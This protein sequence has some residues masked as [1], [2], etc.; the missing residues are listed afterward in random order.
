[1]CG[2]AG[3]VDL[4]SSEIPDVGKQL[5]TLRH[6]GPDSRGVF[7][8]PGV[9]LGQTRLSIIDLVTGDPP[10]TD[11]TGAIGVAFNGEIYGFQRLR[12]RLSAN[13]HVL[14][15]QGDTE[16][17]PHLAEHLAPV[18]LCR[19][20]DG[21]FAFALWDARAKRLVLARDR[22][23]KK[24]LFYWR[25]GSRLVFGSE[26]KAVLAAE[27]VPRDL[28]E[29]A[30]PG[31]L[32][33]GYVPRPHTLFDGVHALGPA[34]VLTFDH[35]GV[36]IERYWSPPLV[37]VDA[38]QVQLRGADLDAELD[39]LLRAAVA[40]RTVA[41]VPVGAFLSG[42]IDSSIVV[43]LLAEASSTPVRT[44]TIGFDDPHGFDERPYAALVAQRYSTEHTEFVV[45][46]DAAELLETLVWHHDQP[47][48]DSSGLPTYL[49]SGLTR[50][51]VTVALSGDG[52]D[53]LFAGYERFAAAVTLRPLQAG[54]KLLRN[55]A[56]RLAARVPKPL[57]R[58]RVVSVQRMLHA[59]REPMPWSYLSWISYVAPEWRR[60]LAGDSGGRDLDDYNRIWL[61]SAGAPFLD[62]LLHLN[63]QTYLPEDLLI[64]VDRMS[65]AHGLEV[66]SPFLDHELAEFAFCM[67]ARSKVIGLSLKRPLRRLARELLPREIL[68]RP[69]H[70]FGVPL[71]RWFR[72][73]LR[74]YVE[75]MLCSESSRVGSHLRRD[76]VRDMVLEHT[77]GV[78][79]HGHA[80]WTLLTLEV[81]LRREGW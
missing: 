26:I 73:D 75:S 37:G 39:R 48:G 46:P 49:L 33:F 11:E 24:P 38:S 64:K 22:F 9:A 2:I 27:G 63:A 51:H 41:D 42:G 52:G 43:A 12:D 59:L 35:T 78:A 76:H 30:I 68:A 15:T 47:F 67:P 62:R 77:A 32:T 21:M 3:E 20:L 17:I 66:R 31:Y 29:V 65:M 79:N 72:E 58:G 36:H 45:R 25:R 7:E 40:R 56:E 70:G 8:Q 61:E 55:T 5:D 14:R 28:N 16:V 1:M 6:R 50:E 18:P 53:E 60:R 13:G 74:G 34:E 80:L 69:K 54:P 4:E 71:D 19:E 23:G 81:F 10:L 44:F 57:R